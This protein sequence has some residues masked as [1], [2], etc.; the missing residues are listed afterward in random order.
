VGVGCIAAVGKRGRG[1]CGG[2]RL[3]TGCSG[4]RL[5]QDGSASEFICNGVCVCVHPVVQTPEAAVIKDGAPKTKH[6][7]LKNPGVATRGACYSG[8]SKA[9]IDTVKASCRETGRSAFH[10]RTDAKTQ[11]ASGCTK[12]RK[13]AAARGCRKIAQ[14]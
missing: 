12:G 3:E 11:R 6:G 14:V 13:A 9:E 7:H 5:L 4:T 8:S 2:P 10:R 1:G